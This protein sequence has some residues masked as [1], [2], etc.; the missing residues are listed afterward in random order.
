MPFSTYS[1]RP[2]RRSDHDQRADPPAGERGRREHD[3]A[4]TLAAV[5][6]RVP[7]PER[8]SAEAR[9]GAP[10]LVLEEH[11]DG[12]R[13][14][15]EELLQQAFERLQLEQPGDVV[16]HDAE[17]DAEQHLH[18]ARAADELQD[19]VEDEGDGQD[20]DEIAPTE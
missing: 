10:D 18:G 5:A 19:V 17:Q 3:V 1:R 13:Q 4:E 8:I 20:V 16:D 15:E 6:V 7:A 9:E 12:E 11:D 2:S 14:H